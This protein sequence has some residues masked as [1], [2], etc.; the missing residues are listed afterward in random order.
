MRRLAC[1]LLLT[2]CGGKPSPEKTAPVDRFDQPRIL[3]LGTSLK[4]P[5]FRLEHLARQ[6]GHDSIGTHERLS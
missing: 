6:G 2:A 5:G 4:R 3:T 1:L